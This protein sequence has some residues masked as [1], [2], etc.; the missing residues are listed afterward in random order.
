MGKVDVTDRVQFENNDDE[1]LP[2]TKCVC[3]ARFPS[4]EFMIS[5]YDDTPY[6]CPKCGAKLVFS[7]SIAV[8]EI[9][10]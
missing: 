8:Y 2:I 9:T 5:I 4:W 6:A 7:F 10:P 3:G 1:Y